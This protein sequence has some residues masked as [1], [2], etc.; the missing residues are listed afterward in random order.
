M[1][2]KKGFFLF[3]MTYLEKQPR[4]I[5]QNPK[6][7]FL[8][9]RETEVLVLISQGLTD[10]EIARELEI[11]AS[12]VKNHVSYCLRKLDA[13]DRTEA[14]VIFTQTLA[15]LAEQ[16]PDFTFKKL[17]EAI[18]VFSRSKNE[19]SFVSVLPRL[20]EIL[21]DAKDLKRKQKEKERVIISALLH[22]SEVR[23]EEIAPA[24]KLS[25][26]TI[27]IALINLYQKHGINH[28]KWREMRRQL[29]EKIRESEADQTSPLYF[30][31]P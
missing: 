23:V 28:G 29:V 11:S 8:S 7:F 19:M 27:S 15:F 26:T 4:E 13:P 2:K 17:Q 18:F 31:L 24:L 30:P 9:L 14:A 1:P 6:K 25:P 10:K 16:C 5:E 3:K 22:N 12:T 21:E 20:N